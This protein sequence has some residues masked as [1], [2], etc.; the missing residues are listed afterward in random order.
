MVESTGSWNQPSVENARAVVDRAHFPLAFE[1]R[2]HPSASERAAFEAEVPQLID[3]YG[4]GSL[5]VVRSAKDPHRLG[6][7]RVLVAAVDGRI[8]PME[9]ASQFLKHLARIDRA[10][11]YARPAIRDQVAAR[12]RERLPS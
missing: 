9:R 11:V 2:E 6:P 4:A 7:S 3:K 10:R 8:E 12:L 1:T 5:L